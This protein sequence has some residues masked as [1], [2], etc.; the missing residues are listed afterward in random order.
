MIINKGLIGGWQ[1]DRS[2][3][4]TEM[5]SSVRVEENSIVTSVA[6]GKESGVSRNDH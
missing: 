6:T 4:F 2:V 3:E 5:M 1:V